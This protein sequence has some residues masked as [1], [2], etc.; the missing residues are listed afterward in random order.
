[1]KKKFVV[2][3][4]LS[5]IVL[6][7]IFG[8]KY[9]AFRQAMAARAHQQMPAVA[10]AVATPQ[11]ETWPT[12][13]AAV[14][15]LT[16]SQ[17][18][19]VKTELDGLVRRVAFTSGA[20]VAAGDSLV[21]LDTSREEAQLKGLDAAVRLAELSLNRARDLREKSTN[22]AADLDTAEAACTQAQAAA[23][24]LRVVIAKKHIVAPFAG[25]LGIQQ[26]YP[27]QF[28]KAGD[29][30]VELESLD[31]IYADFGLPQQNVPVL[32]PGLPVQVTIDAFPGRSFPG[33]IAAVD[34]RI[35]DETRNVRVRAVLGNADGALRPGMFGHAEVVLP[36]HKS[37]LVLPSTAV[38]YSPYGN[39][40]YVIEHG[41]AQQRFVQTGPQRGDL[42][43]VLHGLEPG[44]QVV[45]AGQFKLRNG[46]PVTINN[47]IV[48]DANPAPKPEEG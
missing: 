45:T 37:V 38:V 43:V 3:L 21:D 17:G 24:D 23:Q 34:P 14:A 11:Q 30:V 44:D 20:T 48:P 27:G 36:A 41:V 6:G 5:L 10:V 19:T 18:I 32:H 4:L 2:T 25:R 15:N 33:T 35:T 47:A 46:M 31:P 29:S 40:V 1:M 13:L 12:T 22:S 16:S 7:A 28:L 9:L 26:V 39:S 42:I 8:Y